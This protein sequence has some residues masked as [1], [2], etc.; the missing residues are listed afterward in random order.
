MKKISDELLLI[1]GGIST[2]FFFVSLVYLLNTK[3]KKD[4]MTAPAQE[5]LKPIENV[6]QQETGYTF[7][8]PEIN[9][10]KQGA[11]KMSI[12]V[13]PTK[14]E[15]DKIYIKFNSGPR[16]FPLFG[17]NANT[18]AAGEIFRMQSLQDIY[19]AQGQKQ[20]QPVYGMNP[21]SHFQPGYL[22]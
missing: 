21:Y 19:N 6:I 5:V 3:T 16:L 12:K 9:Q 10:Y 17:Y 11:E 22:V 14:I 8:R 15:G 2:V 1:G 18:S 13:G 20:V 7:P 4:L